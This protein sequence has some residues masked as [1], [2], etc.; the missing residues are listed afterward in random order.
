MLQTTTPQTGAFN[1]MK[2]LKGSSRDFEV[3]S[4]FPDYH[5]PPTI[6]VFF[7]SQKRYLGDYSLSPHKFEMVGGLAT[8]GKPNLDTIN[9][10]IS[11]A[12]INRFEMK[13]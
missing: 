13:S 6:V 3:K 8:D 12:P 10:K 2:F 7:Q 1:D 9:M 4:L 5:I 11:G